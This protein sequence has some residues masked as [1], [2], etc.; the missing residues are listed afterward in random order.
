MGAFGCSWSR[1]LCFR[2]GTGH[3]RCRR[4]W[5]WPWRCPWPSTWVSTSSPLLPRLASV[6]SLVSALTSVP[7][8]IPLQN[9]CTIVLHAIPSACILPSTCCSSCCS[10]R[11][12]LLII[13]NSQMKIVGSARLSLL[14]WKKKRGPSSP[15]QTLASTKS[16]V[17]CLVMIFNVTI[18]ESI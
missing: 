15:F 8:P 6:P 16:T 12:H 13:N 5:S 3:W 4:S 17:L 14:R 1:R 18:L 9:G 7:S 2:S 11:L 10:E